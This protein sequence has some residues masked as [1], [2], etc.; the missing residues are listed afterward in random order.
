MKLISGDKIMIETNK[1]NR[2]I[3]VSKNIVSAFELHLNNH[4]SS[5]SEGEL[6]LEFCLATLSA[7]KSILELCIKTETPL[8]I[9]RAMIQ[10]IAQ[11]AQD[12]LLADIDLLKKIT[13]N[14]S[15]EIH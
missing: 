11:Q 1:I 14:A 2:H 7:L 12:V 8:E 15:T 6:L 5:L 10:Q 9:R 3:V 4:S 13:H